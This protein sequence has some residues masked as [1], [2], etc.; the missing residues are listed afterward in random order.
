MDQFAWVDLSLRLPA[1]EPWERRPAIHGYYSPAASDYQ[2]IV[3]GWCCLCNDDRNEPGECLCETSSLSACTTMY[4]SVSV[5][6][7][8]YD[9]QV[10]IMCFHY[11]AT[12]HSPSTPETRTFGKDTKC[13]SCYPVGVHFFGTSTAVIAMFVRR[14][15]LVITQC[16]L[17]YFEFP[18]SVTQ[19]EYGSHWQ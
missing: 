15:P 16:S 6:P 5:I 9:V 1:P 11:I 4:I 2:S 8:M 3:C 7:L 13:S 19:L 14:V 18:K 12:R 17:E 10:C